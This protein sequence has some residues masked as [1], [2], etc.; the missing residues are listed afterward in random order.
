MHA[1][2]SACCS[3]RQHSSRLCFV[4]RR[5]AHY[6]F[7]PILEPVKAQLFCTLVSTTS[8][9]YALLS[10]FALPSVHS[11]AALPFQTF[12]FLTRTDSKK[13]LSA[14]VV[15]PMRYNKLRSNSCFLKSLSVLQQKFA[16]A[17]GLVPLFSKQQR[18]A[19]YL[20]WKMLLLLLEIVI[21]SQVR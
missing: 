9:V 13:K 3:L 17:N 16:H 19:Q 5:P 4:Y 18:L 15:S 2:F 11:D 12:C 7:L 20:L 21:L 6:K 8:V 10:L 14:A 1:L